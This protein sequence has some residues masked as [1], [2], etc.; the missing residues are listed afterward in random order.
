MF[1]AAGDLD[2]QQTECKPRKCF[3]WGY[4]YHITAK[5]PNPPKENKK[6][7]RQVHF[8]ERGNHALQK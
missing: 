8:S 7:R 4:E 6:Q 1:C 2:K 5:C 3:R